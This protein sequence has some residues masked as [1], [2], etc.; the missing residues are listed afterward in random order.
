MNDCKKN[1]SNLDVASHVRSEHKFNLRTSM[2]ISTYFNSSTKLTSKR[3]KTIVFASA[4]L[5]CSLNAAA[6]KASGFYSEV[7]YSN[8]SIK[9]VAS[10]SLGIDTV[11]PSAVRLTLG[12]LMVDNFALEGF[13]LQDL[14]SDSLKVD[15][16]DID[17]S[18]KTSY[19]IALRPF[20]ILSDKIELYGRLGNVRLKSEGVAS[21]N[22]ISS[23]SSA[24]NTH[25]LLGAGLGY[26]LNNNLKL[27]AD[28]TRLSTVY[29]FKSSMISVGMRLGF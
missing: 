22:G 11:K 10:N 15:G 21:Y 27:V 13:L 3:M 5:A 28:Y 1:L 4:M 25:T 18:V 29:Q 26:K 17:Y 9:G 23:L 8:F 7:A 16:I 24:S 2:N 14:Q 6:Q 20:V 19:G 12:G